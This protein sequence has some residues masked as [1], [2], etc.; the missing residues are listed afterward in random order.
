MTPNSDMMAILAQLPASI[1]VF[2]PV[3]LV[4]TMFAWG[5]D[6]VRP[7]VIAWTVVMLLWLLA[8]W[9]MVPP[10]FPLIPEPYNYTGFFL[11]G[12][13]LVLL[14]AFRREEQRWKE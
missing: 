4:A 11:V 12:A 3:I 1:Y 2:W 5:L 9:L 7:L 8:R 13:L 14:L 10:L 6:D